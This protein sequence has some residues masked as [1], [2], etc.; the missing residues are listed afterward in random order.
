MVLSQ[1]IQISTPILVYC[2][3]VQLLN[4]TTEIHNIQ[5]HSFEKI[6]TKGSSIIIIIYAFYPFQ[7]GIETEGLQ[8]LAKNLLQRSILKD[9][10]QGR[11]SLK[12][13]LE[14]NRNPSQSMLQHIRAVMD[15]VLLE[16]LSLLSY[17]IQCFLGMGNM[18]M[19]SNAV[20]RVNREIRLPFNFVCGSF[21]FSFIMSVCQARKVAFTERNIMRPDT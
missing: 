7:F 16:N 14:P 21:C 18:S 19:F 17:C 9:F 3:P 4:H 11:L 13:I 8:T 2:S 1:D 20:V 5:C 12:D 15:K 10:V 6:S